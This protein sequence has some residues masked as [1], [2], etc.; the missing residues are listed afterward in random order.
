[1]YIHTYFTYMLIEIK[2]YMYMYNYVQRRVKSS[3][4]MPGEISSRPKEKGWRVREMTGPKQSREI[5]GQSAF[6]IMN[7]P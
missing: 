5:M 3:G 4:P 6:P 1:M 7:V 2:I